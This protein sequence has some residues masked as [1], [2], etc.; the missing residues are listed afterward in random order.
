MSHPETRAFRTDTNFV[1][2]YAEGIDKVRRSKGLYAFLLEETTNNYESGRKPCDT[3]KIGQNLNTLGY[4][5]A[6]KIGNPLR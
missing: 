2:S 4:G 3:M 5:I 6:T 1:N